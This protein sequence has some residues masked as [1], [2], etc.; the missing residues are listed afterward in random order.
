MIFLC[1]VQ[2]EECIFHVVRNNGIED[3]KSTRKCIFTTM[4][5]MM[6]KGHEFLEHRNNQYTAVVIHKTVK[7]V[8]RLVGKFSYKCV[9]GLIVGI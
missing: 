4:Y 1:F 5:L 2:S 7:Y 9:Y 6:P 3:T 8:H